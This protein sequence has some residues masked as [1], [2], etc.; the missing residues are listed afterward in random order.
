MG[1]LVNLDDVRA[2]LRSGE[3]DGDG[4]ELFPLPPRYKRF[5]KLWSGEKIAGITIDDSPVMRDLA[6]RAWGITVQCEKNRVSAVNRIENLILG[7]LSDIRL[8]GLSN[9][10]TYRDGVNFMWGAHAIISALRQEIY[11]NAV[12]ECPHVFA[13][14]G[15]LDKIE[16]VSKLS[17][18]LNLRIGSGFTY[19]VVFAILL[20]SIGICNSLSVRYHEEGTYWVTYSF[21]YGRGGVESRTTDLA[22]RSHGGDDQI[23][24]RSV[25]LMMWT[26]Q[27][28]LKNSIQLVPD[29]D[30]AVDS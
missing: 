14:P 13:G 18:Q 26:A 3:E 17:V 15:E 22:H 12:S 10:E 5:M 2:S 4:G 23:E 24:P 20:Y 25:Q 11:E 16:D 1:D 28:G 8:L 29:N 7:F 27:S 19:P 21:S 9:F 6:R 30:T